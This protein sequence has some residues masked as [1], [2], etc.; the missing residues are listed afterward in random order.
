MHTIVCNYLGKRKISRFL[1][2]KLPDEQK[3][4]RM[5]TSGDLIS[6]CDQNP[7][8][9]KISSREMRPG[10]TSSTR[11]QNGNRWRG[12]QQL[13]RFQ[14]KSLQK[15]K[16]KTLLIT[17]LDNKGIIH[18]EFLPAGQTINATF[19]Q[20]VLNICYSVSGGFGQSCIGLENGCSSTIISL[21]TVGSVC[22][23]SW[24]RRW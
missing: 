8:F 6:L 17:F 22:A 3:A 7:C 12:V 11:N 20:A 4:E 13:S 15:S 23:D 16:V 10:A 24:L 5:E 1:L 14:K 19:Y 9:W 2:R 18:K 21:H